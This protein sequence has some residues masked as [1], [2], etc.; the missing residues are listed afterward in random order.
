L[1]TE[2]LVLPRFQV[3]VLEAKVAPVEAEP[4]V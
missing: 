2:E 1:A 3:T 4:E